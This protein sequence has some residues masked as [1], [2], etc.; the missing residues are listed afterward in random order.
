MQALGVVALVL[1]RFATIILVRIRITTNTLPPSLSSF[2]DAG[3]KQSCFSW[4]CWS[5]FR[6]LIRGNPA[7]SF[8]HARMAGGS[9]TCDFPQQLPKSAYSGSFKA[10]GTPST[11]APGINPQC[12]NCGALKSSILPIPASMVWKV[13]DK[14]LV[15]SSSSSNHFRDYVK[16]E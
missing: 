6:C 12:K 10:H 8:L 5:F 4:F 13:A 11:R 1:M 15:P 9:N 2:F 16:S 3:R 14:V 7:F